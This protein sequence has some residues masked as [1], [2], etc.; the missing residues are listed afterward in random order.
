MIK[1]FPVFINFFDFFSCTKQNIKFHK[2][3]NFKTLDGK[4]V[5]VC[6]EG[7]LRKVKSINSEKRDCEEFEYISVING[8]EEEN[9]GIRCKTPY[10][11]E[12][13]R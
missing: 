8:V 13:I 5:L 3:C 9:S 2:A 10:G 11:Y 1:F 4:E 7:M 12:V 6:D